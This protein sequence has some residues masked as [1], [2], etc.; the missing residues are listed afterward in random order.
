[1]LHSLFAIM[2]KRAYF[3]VFLFVYEAEFEKIFWIYVFMWC[4]ILFIYSYLI[5]SS[6]LYVT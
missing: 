2:S 3:I 6:I 1:M 5:K 4:I